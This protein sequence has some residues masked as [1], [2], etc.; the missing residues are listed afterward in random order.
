MCLLSISVK[1]HVERNCLIK[2][3]SRMQLFQLLDATVFLRSVLF[4]TRVVGKILTSLCVI[5]LLTITQCFPS[6]LDVYLAKSTG[7][8]FCLC[9][10]GPLLSLIH[11][12]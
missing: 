10:Q 11:M 3:H 8:I 4:R 1:V 9:P 5:Y 2:Q 7:L 12:Y 6:T